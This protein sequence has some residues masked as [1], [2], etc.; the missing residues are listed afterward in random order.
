[1]NDFSDAEPVSE[2]F[3]TVSECEIAS[4]SEPTRKKKIRHAREYQNIDHTTNPNITKRAGVS[5]PLSSEN[6]NRRKPH[7][8]TEHYSD[9]LEF[10]EESNSVAIEKEAPPPSV[11]DTVNQDIDKYLLDAVRVKVDLN[12]QLVQARSKALK[13][14]NQIKKVRSIEIPEGDEERMLQI[15][16]TYKEFVHRTRKL[17]KNSV[18]I[19]DATIHTDYYWRHF[20]QIVNF[21]TTLSLV[22]LHALI[23][24][25]YSHE[26][27]IQYILWIDSHSVSPIETSADEIERN[28]DPDNE[29]QLNYSTEDSL[30]LS[31]E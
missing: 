1:M 11:H 9:D 22:Q 7:T 12:E 26:E 31:S 18:V 17:F 15:D 2:T 14:Q 29:F 8:E 28:N 16:E 20:I 6:L 23:L 25:Q 4:D 3:V 21:S 24:P 19:W 13:T 10:P 5:V 27:I 30:E